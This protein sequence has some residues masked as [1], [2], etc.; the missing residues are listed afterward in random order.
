[1]EATT[2]LHL[3]ILRTI[4][5][6]PSELKQLN[7]LGWG[8]FMIMRLKVLPFG[9]IRKIRELRINHEENQI[10]NSGTGIK[11]TTKWN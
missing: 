1:M 6:E 3:R 4:A 9:A 11:A 5:Y 10:I 7:T 8:Q 2:R